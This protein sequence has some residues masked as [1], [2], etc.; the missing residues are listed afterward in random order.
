MAVGDLVNYLQRWG[1][2]SEPEPGIPGVG[3][4]I[5]LAFFIFI[6]SG[7]WNAAFWKDVK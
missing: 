2:G 6:A 3:V 5:F 1:A 4:L 7:A